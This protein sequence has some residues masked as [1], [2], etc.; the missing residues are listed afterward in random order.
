MK[1]NKLDGINTEPDRAKVNDI[2]GLL[3]EL[4]AEEI[5][6]LKEYCDKE[7]NLKSEGLKKWNQTN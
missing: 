2:I 4:N 6:R 3:T 7:L 1:P 5:E